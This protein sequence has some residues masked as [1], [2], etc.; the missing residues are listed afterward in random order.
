MPAG[1]SSWDSASAIDAVEA[2][3]RAGEN[4][5]GDKV[6]GGVVRYL[7]AGFLALITSGATIVFFF[8]L[9]FQ[10]EAPVAT[11]PN[12]AICMFVGLGSLA[13]VVTVESAALRIL[14][15]IAVKQSL[16][17]DADTDG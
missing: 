4:I 10:R 5:D 8:S 3:G 14:K 15:A 12:A 17:D 16:G 6:K 11:S 2:S 7:L 13:I 9:S 1:L